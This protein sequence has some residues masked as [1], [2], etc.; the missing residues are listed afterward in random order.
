MSENEKVEL[1]HNFSKN[2][3]PIDGLLRNLALCVCMKMT[4]R[5]LF[6][7][8]DLRDFPFTQQSQSAFFLFNS[9]FGTQ[10]RS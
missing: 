2:T 10:E 5:Y 9:I 4:G 3:V 7:E 1:A 6:R 8:N